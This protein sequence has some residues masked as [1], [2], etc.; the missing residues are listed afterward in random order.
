MIL[1]TYLDFSESQCLHLGNENIT[2]PPPTQRYRIRSNDVHKSI[3][4]ISKMMR[5]K[6]VGPWNQTD[7]DSDVVLDTDKLCDPESNCLGC[8]LI[9]V[10]IHSFNNY[11]TKANYRSGS[12]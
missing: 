10:F 7:L 4:F 11:V 6:P 5:K 8:F 9:H 1:D 3:L 2:S 12:K